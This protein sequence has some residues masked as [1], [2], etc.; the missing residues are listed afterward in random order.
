MMN[1]SDDQ[2]AS[3]FTT[4]KA[5]V[6]NSERFTKF[7]YWDLIMPIVHT[8]QVLGL[9]KGEVAKRMVINVTRIICQLHFPS[10]KHAN[11]SCVLLASTRTLKNALVN[12]PHN[13]S[14]FL[15][16]CSLL[17]EVDPD[18]EVR[19]QMDRKD[20][21]ERKLV[22]QISQTITSPISER[23][24]RAYCQEHSPKWDALYK[25]LLASIPE[26]RLEECDIPTTS[27]TK[28]KLDRAFETLLNARAVYGS[29]SVDE[30]AEMEPRRRA[31]CQQM[32]AEMIGKFP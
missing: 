28:R 14:V 3:V 12:G 7:R 4:I 26:N 11:T 5:S 25:Y 16:L 17:S 21:N 24:L 10:D 29:M 6:V 9:M 19:A 22:S 30:F 27:V 13:H 23:E 32:L 15:K 2:H 1:V 8:R 20:T 31:K 18:W